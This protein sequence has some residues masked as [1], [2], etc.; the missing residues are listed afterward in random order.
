[1]ISKKRVRRKKKFKN[2]KLSDFRLPRVRV[3]SIG[4]VTLAI[5]SLFGLVV[6]FT[7][8]EE[9]EETGEA[10]LLKKVSY[11]GPFYYTANDT[12][13]L[14]FTTSGAVAIRHDVTVKNTDNEDGIFEVTSILEKDKHKSVRTD[15]VRLGEGEEHIFEILHNRPWDNYTIRYEVTPENKSQIRFE[16][17]T[18]E[19]TI[20]K[21]F[22]N[23]PW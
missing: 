14:G 13:S 4:V 23:W 7:G 22:W 15:V 2:V 5:F 1:M 6:L 20:T 9:V 11:F 12:Y 21:R 17:E 8:L 10:T 3:Y 18:V 16:N 19:Y